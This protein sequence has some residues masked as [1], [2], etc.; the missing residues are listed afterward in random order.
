MPPWEAE[1]WECLRRNAEPRPGL[2]GGG[3]GAGTKERSRGAHFPSAAS[4]LGRNGHA[5]WGE[6]APVWSRLL[7]V[8]RF[9]KGGSG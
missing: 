9:A 8:G 5:G 2:P 4:I 3:D 1:G 7:V 6:N